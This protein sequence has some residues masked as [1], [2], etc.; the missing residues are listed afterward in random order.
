MN[1]RARCG[2][3]PPGDV[4]YA[5]RQT[6][7]RSLSLFEYYKERRRKN[8][9]EEGQNIRKTKKK[10]R[11]DRL[12]FNFLWVFCRLYAIIV[13]AYF[14]SSQLVCVCMCVCVTCLY[15]CLSLYYAARGG[16]GDHG[17]LNP[18]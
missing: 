8:R 3:A 14:T 13:V 1:K 2:V 9:N 18:S 12:V 10:S 11:V 15:V 4:F 17:A 5:F 7:T 16:G 6:P